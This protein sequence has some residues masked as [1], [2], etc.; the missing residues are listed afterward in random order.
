MSTISKHPSVDGPVD[1][2]PLLNEDLMNMKLKDGKT[3]DGVEYCPYTVTSKAYDSRRVNPNPEVYLGQAALSGVALSEQ[4]LLDV[5]CGTGSFLAQMRPFFKEVCGVEY[6]EGMLEKAVARFGGSVQLVQGAAQA[7]PHPDDSFDLVTIN[8]VVHHFNTADDFRQLQE[9][10]NEA[11]RVLK[12]GGRLVICTSTP[13]QQRDAF[14]WLSL[15]PKA[16]DKICGRFPPLETLIGHIIK[17][18]MDVTPEGVLVPLHRSLMAPDLY[19]DGGLELAF[20]PEYRKC[21]S[22]WEMVHAEGELEEGQAKI[23]QMQ[24]DGTANAWLEERERLRKSVGQA[25]FVVGIKSK[26]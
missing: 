6:N 25:T 8:Q 4:R 11:H 10:M 22:S 18:G 15:F 2:T 23:R 21:D 9:A 20:D 7:L 14:W 24:S 5:G 16:S 17:A 19:L 12:P 26:P 1:I 13:E 3:S